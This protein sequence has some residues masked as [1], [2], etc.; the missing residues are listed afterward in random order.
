[1]KAD[2]IKAFVSVKWICLLRIL[3]HLG[4]G[5]NFVSYVKANLF[6]A[7]SCVIINGRK[8]RSFKISRLVCQGCPLSPLLFLFVMDLFDHMVSEATRR[9]EIKGLYLE[10][11]EITLCQDFYA[12]NTTLLVEADRDNVDCCIAIADSFA[13]LR[14]GV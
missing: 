6:S 12:D 2:I 4:F 10:E 5:E 1:M 8:S 3:R 7:N 11:Q 14:V 9:G 13:S